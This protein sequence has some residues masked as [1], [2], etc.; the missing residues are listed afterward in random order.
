[1]PVFLPPRVGPE[2]ELRT[3]SSEHHASIT[4]DGANRSIIHLCG[5]NLDHDVACEHPAAGP[6]RK[7]KTAFRFPRRVSAVFCKRSVWMRER[8]ISFPV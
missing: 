8:P 2:F 1:M 7:W 5:H 6:V 4:C 3:K